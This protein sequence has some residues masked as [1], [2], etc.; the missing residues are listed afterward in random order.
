MIVIRL[1]F[2][3]KFFDGGKKKNSPCYTI[4]NRTLNLGKISW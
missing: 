3:L 1:K 2:Q 4:T